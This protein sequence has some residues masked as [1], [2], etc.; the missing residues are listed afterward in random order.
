[1]ASTDE[2]AKASA[3]GSPFDEV[4]EEAARSMSPPSPRTSQPMM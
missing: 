4:E 2:S 1:M 3:F